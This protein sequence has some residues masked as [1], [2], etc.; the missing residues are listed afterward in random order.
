MR[1]LFW[2]F[3]V[4][5]KIIFLLLIGFLVVDR[6][7]GGFPFLPSR[8]TQPTT[9]PVVIS[10]PVT[11]TTEVR[12]V[13]GEDCQKVVRDLIADAIANLPSQS[14]TVVKETSVV[15]Q[16][17]SSPKTTFIP[18]GGSA[19][20]TSQTWTDV[21]GSDVYISLADYT[22]SS[23]AYNGASSIWVGFDATIKM[24]GGNGTAYARLFDVTHGIA[25]SGSEVSTAS[26]DF[27]VASAENI[28]LWAGNNVYRAQ[29]KSLSGLTASF[30]S[31]R[32][33]IVTK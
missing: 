16:K 30:S 28:S 18:L 25:V 3:D 27:T 17:K 10:Q 26:P 21:K 31:G 4:G 29:I 9:E 12:D 20:T 14:T 2:K 8:T 7:V 32:V 11:T 5:I 22:Q 6:V 19:S 33:K 15:E 1:E 13:C 24:E 23:S